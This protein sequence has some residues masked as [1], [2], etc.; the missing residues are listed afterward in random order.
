[1]RYLEKELFETG[2]MEEINRWVHELLDRVEMY[3]SRTRCRGNCD[4]GCSFLERCTEL[5]IILRKVG[6]YNGE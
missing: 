6:G 1:M 5:K 2:K 3:E 4:K